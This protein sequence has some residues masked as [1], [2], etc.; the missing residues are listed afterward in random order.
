MRV[1]YENMHPNIPDDVQRLANRHLPTMEHLDVLVELVSA[2]PA[3][4]SISE[5]AQASRIDA[6]AAELCVAA[7]VHAGLAARVAGDARRCVYR[8]GHPQDDHAVQDLVKLY[9]T[10]PVSLI[11]YMFEREGPH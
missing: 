6:A 1:P 4:R 7:L 2:A 11:R 8:A 5:L 3:S 10:R 9:L